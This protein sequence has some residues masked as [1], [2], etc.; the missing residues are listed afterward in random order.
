MRKIQYGIVGFVT[1]IMLGLLI[2][3]AVMKIFKQLQNS[4]ALPFVFGIIVIAS[5]ITGVSI[6]INRAKR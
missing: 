6:G 5:A 4:A 2:G 1:G 3:L